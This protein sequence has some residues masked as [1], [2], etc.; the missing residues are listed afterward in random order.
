MIKIALHGQCRHSHI[1]VLSHSHCCMWG[2]V[3]YVAKLIG[4]GALMDVTFNTHQLGMTKLSKL[5]RND[6]RAC[7]SSYWAF[8]SDAATLSITNI[9]RPTKKR[10]PFCKSYV[11]MHFLRPNVQKHQIFMDWEFVII[12]NYLC[13]FSILIM[14]LEIGYYWDDIK[15]EYILDEILN[16]HETARYGEIAS[17]IFNFFVCCM[18][19]G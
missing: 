4:S 14:D 13:W 7:W 2:L 10:K 11:Q 17:A 18:E 9:L 16:P 3:R 19:M 12:P 15:V 6:P 1:H 8:R 5:E